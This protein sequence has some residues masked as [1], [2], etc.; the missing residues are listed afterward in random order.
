MRTYQSALVQVFC[1]VSYLNAERGRVAQVGDVDDE[2]LVAHRR[3]ADVADD[4]RAAGRHDEA[5]GV[6]A[7]RHHVVAVGRIKQRACSAIPSCASTYS[8]RL[9]QRLTGSEVKARV[10]V[11]TY[12]HARTHL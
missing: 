2:I 9:K 6:D 12:A 1:F 5:L 7:D 4:L 3:L 11:R 10:H 8:T